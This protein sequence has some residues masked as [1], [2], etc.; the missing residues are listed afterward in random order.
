MPRAV[1]GI[2]RTG[3]KHKKKA[4]GGPEAQSKISEGL[5]GPPSTPVPQETATAVDQ[6]A[7]QAGPAEDDLAQ[8]FRRLR[9]L[10]RDPSPEPC[11]HPRYADPSWNG[12]E[13]VG[14][15]GAN[16]GA[17]GDEKWDPDVPP[18]VISDERPPLVFGSEE[19]ALAVHAARWLEDRLPEQFVGD[20][21][22]YNEEEEDVARV[23]YRHA[24]RRL[25]AAFPDLEVPVPE[26]CAGLQA[27][28]QCTRPCPCGAGLLAKWPWVLQTPQLG[29]C[30]GGEWDIE[31]DDE[32]VTTQSRH[33]WESI[34]WRS[35]WIKACP[36]A[37][38]TDGRSITPWKGPDDR[39]SRLLY[40][41]SLVWRE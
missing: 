30:P 9:C 12:F 37:R 38:E 1:N 20:E 24:L 23:R 4:A 3:S 32:E 28:L 7:A 31:L 35:E 11:P 15:R 40:G 36:G 22:A 34:S 17:Y 41:T 29:F 19:A 2:G 16:S 5:G 27:D 33:D 25:A 6:V 39:E 10:R 13:K 18:C 8:C 21:G 26:L 14:Y